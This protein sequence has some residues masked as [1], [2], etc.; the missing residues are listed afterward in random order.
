M[1]GDYVVKVFFCDV[2]KGMLKYDWD[3]VDFFCVSI[4]NV[5]CLGLSMV[6]VEEYFILKRFWGFFFDCMDS[7]KCFMLYKF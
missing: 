4:E 2:L 7:K 1:N 6:V 5:I 3:F